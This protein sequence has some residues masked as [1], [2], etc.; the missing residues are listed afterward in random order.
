VNVAIDGT[1]IAILAPS[2]PRRFA[3]FVVRWLGHNGFLASGLVQQVILCPFFSVYRFQT[4]GWSRHCQGGDLV[5][6]MGW[7]LSY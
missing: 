2:S 5:A 7:R 3:P 4:A 1:F 6:G